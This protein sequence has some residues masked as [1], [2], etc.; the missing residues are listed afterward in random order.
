MKHVVL[1]S[2]S[3]ESSSDSRLEDHKH[4]TSNLKKSKKKS[5]KCKHQESWEAE[6]SIGPGNQNKHALF[7]IPCKKNEIKELWA[8]KTLK[9]INSFEGEAWPCLLIKYVV[10]QWNNHLIDYD[11]TNLSSFRFW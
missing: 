3:T 9:K 7:R 4:W 11:V 8:L 5:Y 2:S 10:S 1:S 6:I